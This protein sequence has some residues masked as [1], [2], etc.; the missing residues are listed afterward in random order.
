MAQAVLKN[1]LTVDWERMINDYDRIR[2]RIAKTVAGCEGYN[3]KV[4]QD[5]GFYLPNPPRGGEFPTETGKA[6]FKSTPLEKIEL[7]AGELLMTTIRSHDQFNTTV[8]GDHDR[9]RGISGS[10]RVI[11]MNEKDIAERN[12]E[13]GEVVDITGYFDGE[14]RHAESFIVVPYPIPRNCCATYFPEA[15]VLVPLKSTA[16]RSNC[17]TS[18]S[19]VVTVAPHLHDGEKVF[20]GKFKR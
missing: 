2:E 13:K 6:V 18:K 5:G 11:L 9:Y 17:P 14:T 1:K 4:R 7:N 10:R 15:N 19:V 8:Y 20:A 3:Q 16:E 12:L